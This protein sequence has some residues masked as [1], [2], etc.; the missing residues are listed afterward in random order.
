MY[1]KLILTISLLSALYCYAETN[2]VPVVVLPDFEV[3]TRRE[4][5]RAT[6]ILLESR[7]KQMEYM[8]SQFNDEKTS[9]DAKGYIIYLLGKLRY[10]EAIPFLV[11]HIDFD[12]HSDKSRSYYMLERVI[13]YPAIQSLYELNLPAIQAILTALKIETDPRRRRLMLFTI[14]QRGSNIGKSLIETELKNRNASSNYI[15]SVITEYEAISNM[16]R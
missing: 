11:A 15:D 9:I 8:I 2:N 3:A 13:K 6:S 1:T 10:D 16:Y 14:K 12:A 7:K 5:N 4:L